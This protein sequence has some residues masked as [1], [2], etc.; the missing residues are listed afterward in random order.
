MM[1]STARYGRFEPAA[2]HEVTMFKI[3][4]KSAISAQI[5][6]F[7]HWMNMSFVCELG[8]NLLRFMSNTNAT[9]RK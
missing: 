5:S 8:L 7:H 2:V 9:E 1:Q 6:T 3:R 4:E